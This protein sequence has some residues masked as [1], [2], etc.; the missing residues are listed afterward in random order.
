VDPLPRLRRSRQGGGEVMNDEVLC[1]ECGARQRDL[2]DY[3]WNVNEE[4]V[5]PCGSC[6]KDYILSRQV[7]VTY[8]AVRATAADKAVTR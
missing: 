6:G 2:W 1:P 3:D 7:S 5:V 8:Y 4:K